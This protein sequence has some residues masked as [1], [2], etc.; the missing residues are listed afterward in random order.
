MLVKE[1]LSHCDCAWRKLLHH[2]GAHIS[3][4]KCA[5]NATLDSF[6]LKNAGF[7]Y[8]SETTVA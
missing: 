1:V 2:K 3:W 4:V 6:A 8:I 5:K 7:I